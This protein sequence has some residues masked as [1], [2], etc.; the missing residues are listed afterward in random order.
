MTV[1]QWLILAFKLLFIA[2]GVILSA[3]HWKGP[4]WQRLAM[5]ILLITGGEISY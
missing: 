2:G 1:E 3:K 5:I 4:S